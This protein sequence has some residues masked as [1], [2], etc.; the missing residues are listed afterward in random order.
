MKVCP[1]TFN[2]PSEAQQLHGL[3]S[4]LCDRLTKKLEAHCAENGLPMPEMARTCGFADGA[5]SL[6]LTHV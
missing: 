3:G 6:G 2:H 1:L 4:K 5:G